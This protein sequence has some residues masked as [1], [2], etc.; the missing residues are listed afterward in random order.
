MEDNYNKLKLELGSSKNAL[1]TALQ[2]LTRSLEILGTEVETMKVAMQTTGDRVS[3][4]EANIQTLTAEH[5][6]LK[7]DHQRLKEQV[8]A[9]Q[10]E[11]SSLNETLQ[12][13]Q[14]TKNGLESDIANDERK[15]TELNSEI[16]NLENVIS[17]IRDKLLNA[18]DLRAQKVGV[19]EQEVSDLQSKIDSKTMQY[20]ILKHFL[21]SGYVSDSHFDVIKV[22]K[23]PG[24]TT[25]DQLAMSS[26]VG[27]GTVQQ[28]LSALSGK[29]IVSLEGEKFTVI[30]DYQL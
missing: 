13:K 14:H 10:K 15:L 11:V 9:K 29:G 2:E 19:I 23:Q 12:E 7:Q 1:E 26:G 3:S 28:T 30:K 16:T 4:L 25:I 20:K 24:L 18:E 5:V 8:E 6:Q 22:M 17:S 21:D 27:R